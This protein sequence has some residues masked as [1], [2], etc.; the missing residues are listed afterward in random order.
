MH[1]PL[2][3][4]PP[5]APKWIPKR[6]RRS[7]WARDQKAAC[8]GGPKNVSTCPR[9]QISSQ[10]PGAGP[11]AIGS[12]RRLDP[13][14]HH[15]TWWR[16]PRPGRAMAWCGAPWPS[17]NLSNGHFTLSPKKSP[18]HCSNPCSCSSCLWFSISLLIP[19]LLLRFGAFVLRYVTPPIVQVEFCLVKYLL[20]I[21]VL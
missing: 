8:T 5:A 21:L 3:A 13:P 6:G 12:Y 11:C 2:R 20:S 18:P 9:A 1:V 19:S 14:C 15:T 16:G 4:S 10:H 7:I 17:T